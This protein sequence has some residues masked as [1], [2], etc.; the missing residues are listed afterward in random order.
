L[1]VR[2]A[3]SPFA[4]HVGEWRNF[5]TQETSEDLV[6]TPKW[7]VTV[8]LT[9]QAVESA[10][11]Q[12]QRLQRAKLLTLNETGCNVGEGR[13]A[14]FERSAESGLNGLFEWPLLSERTAEIAVYCP[15]GIGDRKRSAAN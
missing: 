8:A 6:E 7:V 12:R 5:T 10:A 15:T 2:L 3:I 9:M 14:Q 11:R 1:H 4:S 13:Q